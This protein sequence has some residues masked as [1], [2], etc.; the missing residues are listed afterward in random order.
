M[1]DAYLRAAN[2]LPVGQ[3]SLCHNPSQKR[4]LTPVHHSTEGEA[5]ILNRSRR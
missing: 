3:I 1:M 2:D 5:A 4:S